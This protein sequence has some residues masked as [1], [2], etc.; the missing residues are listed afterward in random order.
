MNPTQ[1]TW[2]LIR[3]KMIV[4]PEGLAFTCINDF[5]ECYW[6]ECFKKAIERYGKLNFTWR[7]T[8]GNT[9]E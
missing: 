1:I 3:Q 7:N 4:N 5:K 2:I 8:N 9:D 6:H